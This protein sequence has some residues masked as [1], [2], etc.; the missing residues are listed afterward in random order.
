MI[1]PLD[2]LDPAAPLD[3]L[4]WLDEVIGDARVVA[5]GESAHYNREYLQL[6]H[7]VLRYLVER[8]GFGAYAMESGFPEG[9]QVDRWVRGGEGELG[10]ALAEGMTSLMGMWTQTGD[11]LR[12]MRE[13]GDLG[14][15][16]VDLPGSMVSML[17][18]LDAVLAYL[19][20]ADPGFQPDPAIRETASSTAAPSAFSVATAMEGYGKLA[21]EARDALTAG[22][23]DLSARLTGHRL[24]YVRRTGAEAYERALRA[25]RVTVDLDA[26]CRRLPDGDRES[27]MLIRDAAMADTLEWILRKEGRIVLGAHNGHV[28][29]TPLAMPG[30][31]PV[32]MLGAH[33]ADRLGDD[34]LVIG[35]TTG[36]GQILNANPDF[37]TGTLFVP[38]QAP[39]P[40]SLDAFMA[41]RHD[42]LF[43]LDL[44]RL[45]P[46][47]AE[48]VR[49]VTRQRGGAGEL[50]VDQNPL[51]AFDVVIHFPH[52]TPADPDPGA[53][54]C[55]SGDV[56]EAFTR[57]LAVAGGASPEGSDP[58]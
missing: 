55:A 6:R 12:W 54:A 41:A 5:F 35:T 17:P 26:F 4:G 11:Q 9:W 8:H 25:M 44:R 30:T 46:A 14:F 47:D 37:Y 45:S 40:G 43:A 10:R 32:T 7:R 52:V 33:L 34:Y 49:A 1:F 27:M 3:D 31:S 29:R 36:T 56:R 58:K 57:W 28:Q 18:G 50:Y 15:Y 48:A 51:E 21:P 24:A 39:E 38:T 13:R 2:T 23:A 42:G 16:G 20:E 53:L 19:A 22:L